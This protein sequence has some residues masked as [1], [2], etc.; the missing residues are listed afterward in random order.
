MTRF[1]ALLLLMLGL[2]ACETEKQRHIVGTWRYDL[3]ATRLE[4]Q[5]REAGPGEINYMESM[6]FNLKNA[7]LVIKPGRQLE[8]RMDSIVE[9]GS[10]KF[11]NKQQEL[12]LNLTGEDQRSAIEYLS[13]DTLILLPIQTHGINFPRVLV[14]HPG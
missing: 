4:M 13:P 7:E 3:D 6:F 12:L 8:F 5:R 14:D 11:A 1:A 9:T 10:W 2:S